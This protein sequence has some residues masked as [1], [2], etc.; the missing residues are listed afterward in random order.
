MPVKMKLLGGTPGDIKAAK[1]KGFQGGKPTLSFP[2]RGQEKPIE[3]SP[4]IKPLGVYHSRAANRRYLLDFQSWRSIHDK[5]DLVTAD[6]KQGNS[7]LAYAPAALVLKALV[8]M[9]T[10][11]AKDGPLRFKTPKKFTKDDHLV[12][13]LYEITLKVTQLTGRQLSERVVQKALLLL[14]REGLIFKTKGYYGN[15]HQCR[16]FIDLKGYRLYTKLENAIA[17][18]PGRHSIQVKR[19][20]LAR[21]G[22]YG[23]GRKMAQPYTPDEADYLKRND[24]TGIIEPGQTSGMIGQSNTPDKVLVSKTENEPLARPLSNF[25]E[26]GKDSELLGDRGWPAFSL[27][28]QV[29]VILDFIQTHEIFV[30][31]DG[32]CGCVDRITAQEVSA[33][34]R[35]V[36]QTGLTLGFLKRYARMI[37]RCYWEEWFMKTKLGFFCDH[38]FI[39]KKLF[40][41]LEAGDNL[42]E[43]NLRPGG[44]IMDVDYAANM[45]SGEALFR[46][47]FCE[48]P[49]DYRVFMAFDSRID[50]GGHQ[51]AYVVFRALTVTNIHPEDRDFIIGEHRFAAR[52]WFQ[53][54]PE[55]YLGLKKLGHAI[56]KALNMTDDKVMVDKLEAQ[57]MNVATYLERY[58]DQM[59]KANQELC[60]LEDGD[61][62]LD[63]L[64]A[65]TAAP[66][67][68]LEAA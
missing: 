60:L 62:V 9:F 40:Y 65:E 54:N 30:G 66:R 8:A 29:Q 50:D 35:A 14:H 25:N 4:L 5:Y 53:N 36:E 49:A 68:D 56:D 11:V 59:A 13:S 19:F 18:C 16:L 57:Y 17:G 39:I 63:R 48:N 41:S 10:V 37:Q 3:D 26:P 33:V 46:T 32:E 58:R 47:D 34:I 15:S 45:F 28:H 27:T 23:F 38:F 24:K 43:V 55:T 51:S 52:Q 31:R 7:K 22:E 44:K 61:K 21:E 2:G 42:L 6:L 67:E 12:T 64:Y 20:P 1:Q